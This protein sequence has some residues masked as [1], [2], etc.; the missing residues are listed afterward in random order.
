[1]HSKEPVTSHF[2][3]LSRLWAVSQFS[4]SALIMNQRRPARLTCVTLDPGPPLDNEGIRLLHGDRRIP[5]KQP[6]EQFLRS[7]SPSLRCFENVDEDN[8]ERAFLT[9]VTVL[10]RCQKS[11]NIT[12]MLVVY[13]TYVF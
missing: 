1:M 9:R 2:V 12:Q 4:G 5:I 10:S 11:Q 13:Q 3:V 7:P 6:S 8:Q